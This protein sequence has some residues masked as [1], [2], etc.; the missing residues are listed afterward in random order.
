M[1]KKTK[2]RAL[3]NL[4]LSIG[5]LVSQSGAIFLGVGLA[6]TRYTYQ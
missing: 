2:I 3:E 1:S 6:V 4:T 5:E